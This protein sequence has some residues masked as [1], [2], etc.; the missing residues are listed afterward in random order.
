MLGD[1]KGMVLLIR[2]KKTYDR[3]LPDIIDAINYSKI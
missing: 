1:R 2:D 3:L